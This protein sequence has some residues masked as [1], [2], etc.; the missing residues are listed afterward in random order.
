MSKH[1]YDLQLATTQLI[2]LIEGIAIQYFTKK[3]LIYEKTEL[4]RF[5]QDASL[6]VLYLIHI[7]G[8]SMY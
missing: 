4:Q 5:L 6:S 3:E 7:D 1:N 2:T 8:K